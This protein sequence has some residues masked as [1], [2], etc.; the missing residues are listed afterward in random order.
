MDKKTIYIIIIAIVAIVGM[1]LATFI[2]ISGQADEIV[3]ASKKQY[4]I[5]DK[6][7]INTPQYFASA[8]EVWNDLTD[9]NIELVNNYDYGNS[10]DS[11]KK[12]WN[13]T[14]QKQKTSNE[15]ISWLNSL[16]P[17]EYIMIN[18]FYEGFIILKV[19]DWNR[20]KDT[21]QGN[22]N[23]TIAGYVEKTQPFIGGEIHVLS[24]VELVR[25][26]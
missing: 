2:I 17:N 7:V 1:C 12:S 3:L 18:T 5:T 25:V 6:A 23:I 13:K 9:S 8:S 19:N 26:E 21:V 24:N 4:T 20:I 10:N 22:S 11:V 14:S 16:D 15:T